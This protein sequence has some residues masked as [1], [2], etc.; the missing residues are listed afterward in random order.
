MLTIIRRNG[1]EH[2]TYSA[3]QVRTN[4][5]AIQMLIL[6]STNTVSNISEVTVPGTR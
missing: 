1:S 5:I 2:R 4:N 3:Y 6:P